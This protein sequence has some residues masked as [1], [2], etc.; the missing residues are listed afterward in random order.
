MGA[1]IKNHYTNNHKWRKDLSYMVK[2]KDDI[3]KLAKIIYNNCN[4]NCVTYK[5]ELMS[6]RLLKE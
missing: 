4:G 5:R 1:Q 6:Q 2:G 3:P